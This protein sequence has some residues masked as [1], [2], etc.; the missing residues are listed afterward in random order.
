[1]YSQNPAGR[2]QSAAVAHACGSVNMLF[3]LEMATLSI[4]AQVGQENREA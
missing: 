2:K 3:P 4:D 1:V